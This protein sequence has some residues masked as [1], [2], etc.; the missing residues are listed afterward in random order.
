MV[1][2]LGVKKSFK[3]DKTMAETVNDRVSVIKY[4]I[5]TKTSFIIRKPLL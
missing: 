2:I 5:C 3:R 4:N 1:D